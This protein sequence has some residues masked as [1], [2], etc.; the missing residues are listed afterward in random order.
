[1]FTQ[2]WLKYYVMVR[3]MDRTQSKKTPQVWPKIY[4]FAMSSL[5]HGYYI[6]YSLFFFGL[7][8]IDEAWAAINRSYLLSKAQKVLPGGLWIKV[9]STAT[10]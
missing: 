4:A 6:G 5:F 10:I 3:Q 1:M 7:F 8:F 9:L 2:H